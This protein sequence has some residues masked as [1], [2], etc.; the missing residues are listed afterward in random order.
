MQ[1]VFRLARA[2]TGRQHV[3]RFDGHY[4][5]WLD[6]VLGGTLNPDPDVPPHPV[7][8]VGT[9]GGFNTSTQGRAPQ[10]LDETFKIIWN[11][12]ASLE[13][14]L[15]RYGSSIA[16]VH[17]EAI[18]CNFGGCQPRPGYLEGVRELC[19]RHG[20]LLCFDEVIDVWF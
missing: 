18:M 16:L 2:F 9:A 12:L 1:L 4:H 7:D 6:N 17:M 8:I 19:D 20:I 10:S 11:D 13:R 3:L 14:V 5:G 15:D